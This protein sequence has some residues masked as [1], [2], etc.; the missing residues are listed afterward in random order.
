MS[1]GG[2]W[3]IQH[4]PLRQIAKN[5]AIPDALT[6]AWPGGGDELFRTPLAFQLSQRCPDK[7]HMFEAFFEVDKLSKD[8]LLARNE[9]GAS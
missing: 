3:N 2:L 9:R 6:S 4:S 5:L 1:S 8:A 7:I